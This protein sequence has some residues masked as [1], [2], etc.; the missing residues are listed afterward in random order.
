[1]ASSVLRPDLTMATPVTKPQ[2]KMPG[3]SG[4]NSRAPRRAASRRDD[5]DKI[6]G[7][8]FEIGEGDEL[9]GPPMGGLQ[10]HLR[11]LA[12]LQG[13]LPTGG[14]QTPA[15]TGLQAGEAVSGLR[16]GKIVAARARK[17]EELGGHDRADGVRSSIPRLG[18]TAAAAEPTGLG[19]EAARCERLAVHIHLR[20]VATAASVHGGQGYR[21]A[22]ILARCE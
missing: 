15:I 4:S 17:F 16:R 22:L 9:E 14:A 12:R 3:L 19:R 2:A 18:F 8:G 10:Q 13:F 5:S 7:V 6:D 11:C 21:M 1:M 20:V